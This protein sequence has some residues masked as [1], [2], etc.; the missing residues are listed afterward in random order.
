MNA[1]EELVRWKKDFANARTEQEKADHK[2]RFKAYV[3]SLSESERKDFVK[4]YV[5]EARKA[6]DEARKLAEIAERKQKLDGVMTFASMSYIAEHYFGKSRQW[7]Y[8]RIN[9]NLIN[10][11]PADFTADE[12]KTLS[13]AL[14]E[15]GDAMKK[16]SAAIL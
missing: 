14:S 4:E 7:L 10:G 3:E 15:L 2:R 5:A 13:L 8:Q 6:A 12:L 16:A 11:K 1:R 9:G